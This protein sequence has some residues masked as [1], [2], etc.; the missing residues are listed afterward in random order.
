MMKEVWIV[1]LYDDIIK[2]FSS[3]EKAYDFYYLKKAED[4]YGAWIKRYEVE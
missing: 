2:I 4:L 3:A 1:G